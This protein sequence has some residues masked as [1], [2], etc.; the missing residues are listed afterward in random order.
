MSFIVQESTLK[1]Q[2]KQ[3]ST[4]SADPLLLDP[5]KLIPKMDNE[6]FD[7]VVKR[8]LSPNKTEELDTFFEEKYLSKFADVRVLFM[9][10]IRTN[11][12]LQLS[13]WQSKPN[14]KTIEEVKKFMYYY[15]F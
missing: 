5:M 4:R 1:F 6:L 3:K 7:Q 12:L 15:L 10:N 11:I 13:E 2:Q 9:K 14:L 8:L